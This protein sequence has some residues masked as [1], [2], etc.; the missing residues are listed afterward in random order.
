MREDHDD[1]PEP[2]GEYPAEIKTIPGIR[3]ID[4][5]PNPHGLRHR[6]NQHLSDNPSL[7][8]LI[9]RERKDVVAWVS[10]HGAGLAIA[11]S[12]AALGLAAGAGIIL[13]RGGKKVED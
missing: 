13:Y 2:W 10:A 7:N 5:I 11:T 9:Q 12:I 4:T 1:L 8:Y 6:V 3:Q